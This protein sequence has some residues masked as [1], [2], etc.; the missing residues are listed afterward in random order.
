MTTAYNPFALTGKTVLVTGASSGIGRATAIDCARMGATVIITGRNEERLA[1]TLAE[2]EGEGHLSVAAD[3][4]AEGAIDEIV[5]GLPE[6]QGVVL[7]AGKGDTTPIL[8]ATRK[9]FDDIFAIDFFAPVELLRMLLK[10]KKLRGGS[11]AVIISSIGGVMMRNV[12]NGVYEAA[13]AA[14]NSTMM[15]FAKEM[16]PRHIRVNSVCP[17]MVETPLIHGGNITDEQ[18]KAD[19]ALYPLGRY[20][21]PEDVAHACVYLLSDAASWVTGHSLVVDGGRIL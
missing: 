4:C 2:L 6:L 19:E 5:K 10:K 16:G 1:A 15:I 21:Q 9:K 12:A 7:C 14:I 8:F 18:L 3:L 17:G 20:G 13:K 11:S